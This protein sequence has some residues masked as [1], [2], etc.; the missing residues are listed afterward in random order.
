MLDHD[1]AID[2]LSIAGFKL[3]TEFV[4]T[5]LPASF[6]MTATVT[7]AA[8]VRCGGNGFAARSGALQIGPED[9]AIANIAVTSASIVDPTFAAIDVR[10]LSSVGKVTTPGTVGVTLSSIDVIAAGSAGCATVGTQMT[11]SA[12]FDA[13]ACSAAG[14]AATACAV[15]NASAATFAVAA[16]CSEATCAP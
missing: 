2:T 4:A 6:A 1:T 10:L 8:M 9:E 16:S 7:N 11:G 13:C 3:A 15:T 14:S 12:A 5:S